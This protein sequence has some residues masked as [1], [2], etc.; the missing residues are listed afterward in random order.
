MSKGHGSRQRDILAKLQQHRDHPR[1]YNAWLAK[2][3]PWFRGADADERH[4]YYVKWYTDHN[5]EWVTLREL[6]GCDPRSRSFN[7]RP[8]WSDV[9]SIRRAVRKLES[10]GLVE[11]KMIWRN[12]HGQKQL[13]VRLAR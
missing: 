7:D 11:T 12:Q 5:P 4:A 10:E 8:N 1:D 13:G 2:T 9:E 6:A 3:R